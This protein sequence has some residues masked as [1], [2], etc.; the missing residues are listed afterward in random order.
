MSKVLVMLHVC[1]YFLSHFILY[2]SNRVHL[3]KS[4]LATSIPC[5]NIFL[6]KKIE[7][8]SGDP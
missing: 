2:F 6:K 5:L 7:A 1:L 8:H 4:L 3:K